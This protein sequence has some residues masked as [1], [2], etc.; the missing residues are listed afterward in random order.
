MIDEQNQ[1]GISTLSSLLAGILQTFISRVRS[2]FVA[3]DELQ[4]ISL[5]KNCTKLFL[6]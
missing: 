6:H 2:W 1:T 3:N 4:I 5:Q